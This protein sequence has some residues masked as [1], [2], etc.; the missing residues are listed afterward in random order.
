MKAPTGAAAETWKLAL[1]H[2]IFAARAYSDGSSDSL[3]SDAALVAIQDAPRLPKL[4][5][6]LPELDSLLPKLDASPHHEI[7][8]PSPLFHHQHHCNDS[9]FGGTR[10][11]SVSI[12]KCLSENGCNSNSLSHQKVGNSDCRSAEMQGSLLCVEHGSSSNPA[13]PRI[14]PK[15]ARSL[16]SPP[17]GD[18]PALRRRRTTSGTSSVVATATAASAATATTATTVMSSDLDNSDKSSSTT[19]V[20]ASSCNVPPPR[21]CLRRTCKAESHEGP[22]LLPSSSPAAATATTTAKVSTGGAA[23]V[24]TLKLEQRVTRGYDAWSSFAAVRVVCPGTRE[25]FEVIPCGEIAIWWKNN[26]SWFRFNTS[27]LT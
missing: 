20:R 12:D 25:I 13:L 27:L 19:V 17:H 8:H 14:A 15:A 1:R 6:F 16:P 18:G 9:G 2:G 26:L 21:P 22:T 23:V 5:A 24:E 4:D 3:T 10:S 11:N 7:H